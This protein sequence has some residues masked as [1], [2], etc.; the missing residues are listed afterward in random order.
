MVFMTARVVAQNAAI[1]SMIGLPPIYG[2]ADS[3][4]DCDKFQT[5]PEEYTDRN[6]FCLKF[7]AGRGDT[8][9]MLFTRAYTDRRLAVR[10]IAIMVLTSMN[11]VSEAMS[12]VHYYDG[13]R[14]EEEV[15]IWK[16]DI[17]PDTGGMQ[18][19]LVSIPIPPDATASF[20]NRPGGT[21]YVTVPQC[22]QTMNDGDDTKFLHFGLNEVLFPRTVAVD[23]LFVIGGTMRNNERANEFLESNRFVHNPT[24]Y[25]FVSELYPDHCSWCAYGLGHFVGKAETGSRWHR[26]GGGD[27]W[28]G[29]FFLILDTNRYTLTALPDDTARGSVSGSGVYDPLDLATVVATPREGYWF[30][31]WSD[32]VTDNPRQVEVLSD[33][34]L[35]AIFR[36]NGDTT[37]IDDISEFK[38]QNSKFKVFP[39]P[40]ND[41]LY[42]VTDDEGVMQLQLFDAS[43]R[44]ISEFKIQNSKF[45]IDISHLSA[46]QYYIKIRGGEGESVQT[47]VKN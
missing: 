20:G 35:V 3:Y 30:Y 22:I 25:P 31:R 43:G 37:G 40:A 11:D 9:E 41:E 15:M 38:I 19:L 24:I 21:V 18:E 23:S 32:G 34:T 36:A 42:I 44:T 28:S 45:K 46:G 13:S 2:V 16:G 14:V 47:F 12:P 6:Y 17:M 7:Y 10:G 1:D 33:T 26:L 8:T 39:N 4:Q 27:M 5:C 29:P